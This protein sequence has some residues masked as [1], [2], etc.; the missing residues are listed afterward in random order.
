MFLTSGSEN[1]Q[2]IALVHVLIG[3]VDRLLL[4]ST[5]RDVVRATLGLKCG[6]DY[7]TYLCSRFSFFQYLSQDVPRLGSSR[8]QCHCPQL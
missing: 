8:V 7:A 1:R 6:M 2:V 4:P 3:L 5:Y